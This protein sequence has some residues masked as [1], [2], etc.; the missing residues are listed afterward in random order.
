M[1]GGTGFA[2]V[3][4]K[5]NAVSANLQDEEQKAGSVLF[6]NHYNSNPSNAD[7]VNTLFSLTNTN[8]GAGANVR[9]FFVDVANCQTH[10]IDICLAARQTSSFKAS[11]LDPGTKGY[12]V[13]VAIDSAGHPVKFNWLIG[14]ALIRQTSARGP[15]SA[16]LNA[17]IV[18][19][20]TEGAVPNVGGVAELV[21]N[22]EMY[23]RLPAQIAFDNVPSQAS[24]LNA[25]KLVYYRPLSDLAAGTAS[26]ASVQLTGWGSSPNATTTF[27][28][29]NLSCNYGEVLV[30]SLRPTGSVDA[31]IPAETT[32]WIA[33]SV[34][35]QLPLLGVQ[36][37]AGSFAGAFSSGANARPLKF[38]LEYRI[39][40]PVAALSCLQ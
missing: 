20:R 29:Q 36:F 11:D 1:T 2:E 35:D 12:L 23:D 32:G 21:F 17:V 30:R 10:R 13:A 7:A 15:Y 27:N 18:A 19:K 14:Q 8:P 31:L 22:D 3:N 39:R 16:A 6:F 28:S 24:S 4:L 34:A 33:A 25:T 5:L 26:P 9:L 38:S 37:N 40:V